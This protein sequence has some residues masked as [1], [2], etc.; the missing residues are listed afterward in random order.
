MSVSMHNIE[1]EHRHN[2]ESKIQRRSATISQSLADSSLHPLLQ[3]LYANRGV[4]NREQIEYSIQHLSDYRQLKDI[5]KA[6]DIIAECIRSDKKIL[7]VGDFDADG[8]TSTALVMR[9]L[10]MFGARRT[11]YLVPNRFTYGYGLSPEIVA[12]AAEQSPD[13]IITVDNGISSI[14]GVAEANRRKIKVVVTDHHLPAQTKPAAAAIINPNQPGCSFPCK[15]TA[16][17]V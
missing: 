5:K 8:A 9:A 1:T 15:N 10:K 2:R 7:I 3:Q 12:L 14:E 11:G 4:N 13:L 6:A 16:S 17:M